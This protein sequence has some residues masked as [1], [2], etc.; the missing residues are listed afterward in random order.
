MMVESDSPDLSLS[1]IQ[2]SQE[3]YSGID[4]T[5]DEFS[6]VIQGEHPYVL[7]FIGKLGGEFGRYHLG[8]DIGILL[9]SYN[10]LTTETHKVTH[11]VRHS[12]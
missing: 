6:L 5:A 1:S 8:V 12:F 2:I 11:G 3:W 7:S 4:I 10:H 9:S